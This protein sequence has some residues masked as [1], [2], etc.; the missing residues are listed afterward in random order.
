MGRAKLS[1]GWGVNPSICL[2]ASA[3]R[4]VAVGC[5]NDFRRLQRQAKR[6]NARLIPRV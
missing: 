1:G 2:S 3:E 4:G 6:S 5:A